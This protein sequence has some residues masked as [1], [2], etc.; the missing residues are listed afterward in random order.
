MATPPNNTIIHATKDNVRVLAQPRVDS[1]ELWRHPIGKGVFGER[2]LLPFTIAYRE[3]DELGISKGSVV[4]A[5]NGEAFLKIDNWDYKANF[6]GAITTYYRTA[7]L[8]LRDQDVNWAT[9]S[10]TDPTQ[11]SAEA[12]AAFKRNIE[13]NILP[14]WPGVPTPVDYKEVVNPITKV[15]E[16][17]LVFPNGYSA[18]FDTLTKISNAQRVLL[19]DEEKPD[20]GLLGPQPGGG[21]TSAYNLFKI[22][23]GVGVFSFL[24][25][26]MVVAFI[27][28]RR[29]TP[30]P[31]QPPSLPPP[32]M[33][34]RRG[35]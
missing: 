30:A 8:L 11:S 17:Y 7:Y 4:F 34:P 13:E 26:A 25:I 15:L 6:W 18:S 20:P 5:N 2:Q 1:E 29:S 19:T 16:W 12:K 35:R 21:G 27:R 9:A 28:S 3:G 24:A 33:P 32:P 22:L 14:G 31:A 23:A 10:G